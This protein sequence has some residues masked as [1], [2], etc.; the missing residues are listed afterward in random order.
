MP[1]RDEQ[2]NI[3]L[4]DRVMRGLLALAFGSVLLTIAID[5]FHFSSSL[6][7]AETMPLA[8]AVLVL[9]A[10]AATSNWQLGE[11]PRWMRLGLGFFALA[12]VIF[13]PF[14]FVYEAFGT[15][16]LS[17]LALSMQ[18]NPPARMAMIGLGSFPKEIATFL[19]SLVLLI[20]GAWVLV[21]TIPRFMSVVLSLA[22]VFFV[23]SPIVH[24]AYRQV[25]PNPYHQMVQVDRDFRPPQVIERPDRKKNLVIVY[26]ESVERTY[27]D[28]PETA[29]AFAGLAAIEDEALSFR[30]IEQVQGTHFTA[31]GM[32]ASLC[33]APLLPRGAVNIRKR[34]RE[35][36]RNEVYHTED[37]M[38][39]V[40]CLGDILAEDGYLGS[41]MNGSDLA[42][43][44]KGRIFQSHGFSR[45]K[46]V[47]SLP[48]N[49]DENYENVWG[50]SDATLFGLARD[51]IGYLAAQERPFVFSMLTIAT[52]GP[53]AELDDGCDFPVVAESR[54]PAAIHCTGAH[55]EGL[56]DEIERLGIADDTIVV[57]MSDHLAMRNS[58]YRLLEAREADR[59]NYLAVLGAGR[60]GAIERTG[61]MMDVYPTLLELMGYEIAEHRAN[62]GVSLLADVPNLTEE[63][64]S[65]TLSYVMEG[66]ADLQK[67]LWFD[68]SDAALAELSGTD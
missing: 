40:T 34:I 22:I 20:V 18:E 14:V 38:T 44:S 5:W 37:F 45:V 60:S 1:K 66:N 62:F 58:I 41:Y 4:A 21:N 12:T 36:T 55:I 56:L 51:E 31:G 23:A 11:A 67:F 63:L 29:E 52:H 28:I 33:G 30:G 39:G 19:V 9:T 47:N 3:G 10:M 68:T 42:V 24:Y 57:V 64:G 50:M 32:I 17:S 6:R 35:G 26:M 61:S 59:R 16:D 54:I 15:S 8:L 46:G 65:E 43:F 2:S 13:L 48:G 27:R 25:V 7:S 53:D 49:A